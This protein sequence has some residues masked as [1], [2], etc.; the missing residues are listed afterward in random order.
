MTK[1]RCHRVE[2]DRLFLRPMCE[3]DA[4]VVVRWRNSGHVSSTSFRSPGKNIT[5]QEHLIWFNRTRFSR[6]DFIIEEKAERR[7]IGSVSFNFC[8]IGNLGACGELGKY[9]GE[10]SYLGKGYAK[11]ATRFW[12][13]YGFKSLGLDCVFS[14][15]RHDNNVN[16]SLNLGLG[17]SIHPWHE[18]LGG[19]SDEW[20]FMVL[21]KSE[22][23]TF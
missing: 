8:R 3:E 1:V 22:W 23:K 11:E 15:T 6:V 2:T 20:V 13:N 5:T 19:A 14:R 10:K 16:I 18:E 9:I 7:P 12:L 17:F 4:E 21:Q